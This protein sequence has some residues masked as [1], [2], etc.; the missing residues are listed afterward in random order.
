MSDNI[1]PD[2]KIDWNTYSS[3]LGHQNDGGCFRCH[4]DTFEAADGSIIP[5]DFK[6]CHVLLAEDESDPE[7]I[8]TLQGD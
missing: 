6:I 5:Q 3:N 4:N 7:I 2:M 8:S 1:Y